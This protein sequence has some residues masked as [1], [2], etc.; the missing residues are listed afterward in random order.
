[1]RVARQPT[2]KRASARPPVPPSPATALERAF[3]LADQGCLADAA[4]LCQADLNDR[5]PSAQAFYLLGV[6]YSADGLLS[7]ADR[8]YRKALYLDSKH[9]DALLHLAAL[10]EEQGEGREASILRRRAQRL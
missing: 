5:G 8:C 3:E 1:V 6:I 4:T 9:H 7:A 10:L 2:A